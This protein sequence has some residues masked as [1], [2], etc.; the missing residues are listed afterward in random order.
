VQYAQNLLGGEEL[1]GEEP[2]DERSRDGAEGL[3]QVGKADLASRGRKVSG[4]ERAH[5]DEPGA[6][7]EELEEHHRGELQARRRTDGASGLTCLSR[8]MGMPPSSKWRAPWGLRGIGRIHQRDYFDRYFAFGIPP[9]DI[10]DAT[11]R[12]ELSVLCATGELPAQSVILDKLD[13]LP[14]RGRVLRKVLGNLDVIASAPCSHAGEAARYLNRQ[15]GEGD[16]M[17][18]GWALCF[19]RF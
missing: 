4:K 16:R 14:G 6:P 13:D 11:V 1:I 9:G 5:G 7:D 3:G 15:L 8:H 10:R 18:G 17:Y 12:E 19:T 2:D